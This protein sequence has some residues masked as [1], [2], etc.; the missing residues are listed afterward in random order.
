[1]TAFLVTGQLPNDL[2]RPD[3]AHAQLQEVPGWISWAPG[4]VLSRAHLKTSKAF[5]L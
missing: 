3:T 4:L 5:S 2:L 1:M